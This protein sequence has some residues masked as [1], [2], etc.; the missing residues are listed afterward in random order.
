LRP[1]IDS[2]FNV[3]SQPTFQP[4]VPSQPVASA[5]SKKVGLID[6]I[7][8]LSDLESIIRSEKAVAIFFTSAQC[9]PCTTMAPK[10]TELVE[11]YKSFPK[12]SWRDLLIAKA[13]IALHA[14]QVDIGQSH[15]IASR[16]QITAT[17]TFLMF[18]RG[19]KVSG[20]G[21]TIT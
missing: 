15:A 8:S 12:G 5:P 16:Y 14:I 2:M 1:L 17:P 20:F 10:F 21:L 3:R 9:P 6:C 4:S 7:H 19:V 13:S 11:N 18:C